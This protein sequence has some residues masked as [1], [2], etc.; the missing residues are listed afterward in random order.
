MS[1]NQVGQLI[2][3]LQLVLISAA[4][5][6]AQAHSKKE[7]RAVVISTR[8]FLRSMG[9][10]VGL[11]I[12]GNIFSNILRSNLPSGVPAELRV[13]ILAS[14]FSVPELSSVS[15]GTKEDIFEAYLAAIKGVFILWACCIGT[16]LLLT[17]LIKDRGL[18]RKEEVLDAKKATSDTA[19]EGSVKMNAKF[20]I[21]AKTQ[22]GDEEKAL[23]SLSQNTTS[24]E[25]AASHSRP[26]SGAGSPAGGN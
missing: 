14:I 18:K 4:L 17:S 1:F 7:D 13:A 10:A 25:V 21:A 19:L 16:C 6:A 5:I 20:A 26:G 24:E 22:V 11:S 23:P 2:V 9:G 3:A 8:N 12:S 15:A